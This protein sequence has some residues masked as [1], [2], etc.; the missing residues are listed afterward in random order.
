MQGKLKGLA[1][2]TLVLTLLGPGRAGAMS[3]I[4]STVATDVGGG[5]LIGAALGLQAGLIG[6]GQHD[7][8]QAFAFSDLVI[9]S[10]Y[11]GLIGAG[12]GFFMGL[13]EA[14]QARPVGSLMGRD[15]FGGQIEGSVVGALGSTIS[16]MR[17]GKGS[18]FTSGIGVGGLAG[19]AVGL[20]LTFYEGVHLQPGS[21]PFMGKIVGTDVA[22]GI[23]TGAVL[24]LASGLVPYG[25]RQN[26]DP[27]TY[28]LQPLG[29]GAISGSVLG[30]GMGFYEVIV[31]KP[32]GPL[33]GENVAGG[34]MLGAGL[35]C[36]GA[37]I[38][39]LKTKRGSD[40]TIGAGL[41]SITGSVAGVILAFYESSLMVPASESLAPRT[42]PDL[43][44][45]SVPLADKKGFLLVGSTSF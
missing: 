39:F 18:D 21:E 24:G 16:Y 14:T 43:T 37:S 23:V 31:Q 27:R 34:V 36:I 6:Y 13:Y 8:R 17:S 10:G 12:G 22:G 1:A 26:S 5:I 15:V 42:F 25:V 30:L 32:I 4:G 11:G 28:V 9:R 44:F 41:G 2:L 35:G 7:N 40:Y 20:V 38:S 29:W 45:S 19:A 33:M 3:R